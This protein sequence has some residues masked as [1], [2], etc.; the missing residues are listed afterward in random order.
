MILHYKKQGAG[1]PLLILHGLMGSLDNWQL[2]AKKL[3][4]HYTVYSI[5]LRN[6]G[7]SPH[8]DEMSYQAMITDLLA[9][10]QQQEIPTAHLIGHSM[11]GKLAMHLALQ[12]P[13]SISRLIIVDIAPVVYDDR[14][15]SV[16]AAL[17]A[18]PLATIGS[19]LDAEHIIRQYLPDESTVQFLM[20]G[21][22]RT[23]N[24]AFAWRFNLPVLHRAYAD[25]STGIDSASTF[26]GETLFIKGALSDYITAAHY[27]HI[28]DLFPHN[29]L[30]E[31]AGA[32]HWVHADASPA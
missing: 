9:F 10:M 16:F 25:I 12:Q 22:Y 26:M 14:H 29:Q 2:I 11:G 17:E 30:T 32:G 23:D 3:A 28:M 8:S 15:S 27:S 19:R 31:I 4:E 21:L 6:H 18:V 20:K 5:D 7:R 13:A 1:Y 24:Q